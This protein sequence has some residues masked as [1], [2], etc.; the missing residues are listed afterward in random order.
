MPLIPSPGQTMCFWQRNGCS[1][2]G[3]I[4]TWK[5]FY[6]YD[7]NEKD[8]DNNVTGSVNIGDTVKYTTAYGTAKYVVTNVKTVSTSDTSDLQQDG[9]NKITMYT[10]IA[11][12]PDVKLC[13]TA[14]MVGSN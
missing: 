5:S 12:Q 2:W 13:V 1:L 7:I 10:C 3:I 9:Q 11:N 8:K 6:I 14:T 4:R